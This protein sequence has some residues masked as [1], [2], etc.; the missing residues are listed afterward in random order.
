MICEIDGFCYRKLYWVS[1]KDKTLRVVSVNDASAVQ[2]NPLSGPDVNHVFGLASNGKRV[3]MTYWSREKEL[4]TMSFHL[5]T[6]SSISARVNVPAR[7]RVTSFPALSAIYV[8]NQV[9]P[10]GKFCVIIVLH[11]NHRCS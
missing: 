6:G 4:F 2:T 9:Q 11:S 8:S 1:F 3:Y 10:A 5:T 7:R